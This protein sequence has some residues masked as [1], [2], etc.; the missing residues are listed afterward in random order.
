MWEH[1]QARYDRS[2]VFFAH[3]PVATDL[4]RAKPVGQAW[5]SQ[6]QDTRVSQNVSDI[7]D[8]PHVLRDKSVATGLRLHRIRLR[9]QYRNRAK[10]ALRE[11][12]WKLHENKKSGILNTE[13][14]Y[15]ASYSK[16][17]TLLGSINILSISVSCYCCRCPVCIACV[18]LY[19]H[20]LPRW[21]P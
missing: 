8:Y 11:T 20:D 12:A 17:E 21:A 7:S 9:S 16:Q 10:R 2:R 18:Q 14:V 13:L 5:C 19:R 1:H 3:G 4:S 15:N 6:C